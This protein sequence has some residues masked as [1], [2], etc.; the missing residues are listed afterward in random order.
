MQC[1]RAALRFVGQCEGLPLGYWIGI[2][3]DEPVG[4]ND[5]SVKGSRYFTCTEG[6]G[7]FVRPT[8]VTVGDFPPVDEFALSDGDEI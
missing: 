6:F 5:G 1:L 7:S 3:F 4:K 8:N 2:E